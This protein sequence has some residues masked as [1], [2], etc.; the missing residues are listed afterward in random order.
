MSRFTGVIV[1]VLASVSPGLAQE[2]PGSVGGGVE[3]G[4]SVF[5]GDCRSED[6]RPLARGF[7]GE[8]SVNVTDRIAIAGRVRLSLSSLTATRDNVPFAI[9]VREVG[10]AGGVRLH[11]PSTNVRP[12]VQFLA[13]STNFSMTGELAAASFSGFAFSPGAGVEVGLLERTRLR[14]LGEWSTT[15]LEGERLDNVRALV[16]LV[17]AVGNR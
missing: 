17:L 7:F 10:F 9:D 8:G 14:L 12:F 5:T 3:L 6:C 4:Q 2:P 16:G 1:L 11:W 13:G 15:S